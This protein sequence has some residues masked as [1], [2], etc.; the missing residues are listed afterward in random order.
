MILGAIPHLNQPSSLFLI[1]GSS[2]SNSSKELVSSYIHLHHAEEKQLK[3]Y[4][5]SQGKRKKGKKNKKAKK[6]KKN[7]DGKNKTKKETPHQEKMRLEREEKKKAAELKKDAEKKKKETLSKAKQVDS[8][9]MFRDLHVS[10][11]PT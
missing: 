3:V 2:K 7:K 4:Q 10:I 9:G 6:T 5:R 11:N 1:T 8:L